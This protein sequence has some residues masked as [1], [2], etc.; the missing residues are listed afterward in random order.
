[1][2]GPADGAI[3]TATPVIKPTT[4]AGDARAE[5]A[6]IVQVDDLERQD[7]TVAT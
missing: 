7:S 1:M 3:T 4:K 6:T 2:S 5:P